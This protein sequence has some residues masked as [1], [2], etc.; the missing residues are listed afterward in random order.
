MASKT[1]NY[2]KLIYFKLYMCKLQILQ[3]GQRNI[4]DATPGFLRT[5]TL[6]V[7]QR[8]GSLVIEYGMYARVV[9]VELLKVCLHFERTAGNSKTSCLELDG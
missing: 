8:E 9:L 4:K 3:F 2:V 7:G 6:L 1:S 5:S